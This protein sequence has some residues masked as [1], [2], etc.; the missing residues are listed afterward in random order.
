MAEAAVAALATPADTDEATPETS[1]VETLFWSELSYDDQTF[2][3]HREIAVSVLR[4][5]TAWAFKADECR[6]LGFGET[7]E[8]AESMFCCD[9]SFC[10]NEIACKADEKMTQGARKTKQTMLGLVKSVR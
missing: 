1:L 10:W 4:V 3:L 5:G 7:R 6:L 9:F 8:D 2:V